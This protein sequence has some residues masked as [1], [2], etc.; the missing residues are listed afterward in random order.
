MHA[1][2]VMM[3]VIGGDGMKTI[4]IDSTTENQALL[5]GGIVKIV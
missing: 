1:L 4:F 5:I 3:K 2:M